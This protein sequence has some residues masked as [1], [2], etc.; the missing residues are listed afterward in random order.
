[1][2]RVTPIP[3]APVAARERVAPQEPAKRAAVQRLARAL[4][5]AQA[6]SLARRFLLASLL[7]LGVG[8][9]VIGWWMGDQLERGI[10][11][12]TASIT[13]LY[14]D[15]FIEP[16]LAT[17][18]S[19]EWLNDEDI[20]ALDQLLT[21]T[22]FAETIVAM[23][24]WRP[25]GVIEYSPDRSLVGQEFPIE[26]GLADALNGRV[27]AEMSNLAEVENLSES[28]RGYERLLEMYLP[29]RERGSG[30]IIAVAEF[31]QLPTEIERQVADARFQTWL[32]VAAAVAL[33]YLL[34]YGIVR[35]GSETID[36]QR[37]ALETQVSELSALL[38][39]NEQLRQRV[40][41]AA[42]RTTTLSER[43]LRRISSDLHDGP[44]QMLALA[45]LRLD[46]LRARGASD[47]QVEKEVEEL[48]ATLSDALRDMRA[49][50]AGL[51][52]PELETLSTAD[53]VRRAVDDHERRTSVPVSL[54]IG[55]LA[56]EASLP[57]KI[58]LFRAL[59]ELL[60]NSTRHGNGHDVA[61][62]LEDGGGTLRLIVSDGG[63]GIGTEVI[64]QPDRL[65]LAGVREQAE[66]LGGTF[67]IDQRPAG[68]ARVTV[69]WP[70]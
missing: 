43:N 17:L 41:V 55:D 28:A 7:V 39:Q 33:A 66:L 50:A 19:G 14:V 10:V 36:R 16:H 1:M 24:I 32:V 70:L 13:G 54:S 60:S 53:V 27:V 34:L 67:T 64:G 61:V 62:S 8:G 44:A 11:D 65:G 23:K 3:A 58:A 68:G 15:S 30:R 49:V 57:T 26:G 47:K 21:Q 9:V 5:L 59:Q 2:S 22:S 63:P 40:R 45:M 4:G 25:D 6:T 37:L 46:Q 52:L 12:R 42:E 29:V 20:A 35:Q 69:A 31:Y 38:N 18:A 48:Q 51:R 56:R